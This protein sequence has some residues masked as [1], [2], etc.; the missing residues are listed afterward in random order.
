MLTRMTGTKA[1]SKAYERSVGQKKKDSM[2]SV[3]YGFKECSKVTAIYAYL[4]NL[5][6]CSGTVFDQ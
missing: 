6:F 2:L 4:C 3:H 1:L 5:V